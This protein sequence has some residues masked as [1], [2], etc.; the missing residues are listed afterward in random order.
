MSLTAE[1]ASCVS[2]STDSNVVTT[3]P[4][5]VLNV[6]SRCNCRCVMCD[7]W[8]QDTTSEVKA[9]DL[10]RHR[11]SFRKLGVRWVVLSGGEP[12][13]HSDL[14]GLCSFFHEIGVRMT[15]LTTGLLLERRSREVAE[16]FDDVIVSLDGPTEVHDAIRRVPGAFAMIHKGVV[17]Y[18]NDV[19]A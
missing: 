15:L 18:A 16:F 8:R 9:A 4:I 2:V 10:E 17:S 3:L 14:P 19:R 12:L 5:L 7:I 6:H 13:M 1:A 11:A